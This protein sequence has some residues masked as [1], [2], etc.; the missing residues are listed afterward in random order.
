MHKNLTKRS[1]FKKKHN[2]W[3]QKFIKEIKIIVESFKNRL[4]QGEEII[5]Q[6]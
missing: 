2:F 3:K 6:L 1:M 4:D 5:L